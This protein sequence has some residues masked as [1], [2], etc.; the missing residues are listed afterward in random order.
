M[1]SRFTTVPFTTAILAA[2]L[3]LPASAQQPAD[4]LSGTPA[5]TFRLDDIVVT[6]A[7]LPLRLADAPGAITVITGEQL[8]AS[9]V[10]YVADALRTVPG[11]AVVQSSG[12]GALTSVFIRGG[13]SDYV[14]VL[15]DG[16]QVNDP[17]GAFDWAHLRADDIERIEVLRGPASVLYGSDAVSGVV[18]IF[19]R[20][21]G[22]PRVEASAVSGMGDKRGDGAEGTYRT[23]AVDASISGTAAA[24]SGSG[25]RLNYGVSGAHHRSNGLH[26][27]NSDYD[28]TTLS[29]RLQLI[30]PAFDAAFTAR[31]TNHTYHYPT[32][33]SGEIVDTNQFATGDGLSFGVDGGYRI[34]ER[35]ELRVLATSHR[36]DTRTDDPAE[37][38]TEDVYWSTGEQARHKLDARINARLLPG[39]ILTGG[40]EREWQSSRTAYE[41]VS[42]WGV[43]SDET[44]ETRRNTGW[45]AQLHAT[46]LTGVAA[47]VGGRID[48]NAAFGTFRTGRAALSWSPVAA[49]RLH[50]AWGT[51]FKEPTFFE[52]FAT[53]FTR[54]NPELEPEQARSI[55]AGIEQSL[56]GGAVTLGATWFDQRFR[57]LIQYT[58]STP[59]PE[60]PN[61]YNIG[62]ARSRGVE[63]SA[64]A[65]LGRLSSTAHYTHTATR[66]IDA[67]FGEDAAFQQG[68]R[69]LRRPRHVAAL[70]ASYRATRSVRA[71]LDVRHT[72]A[73]DDLDFTDPDNWSGLRVLMPSFTT[74]DAGAELGV[75]R[76]GAGTLDITLR[77]RNLLD[78]RYQEIYNFPAAGRVLQLGFRATG[79]L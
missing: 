41:S 20:A 32:S 60:A 28:N 68:E 8:R 27:F 47:T 39:T 7:R 37:P 63:L 48:E 51:A 4:S 15:V 54:G 64:H 42:A 62:A 75:L 29:A 38:G 31:G 79:G 26:A 70:A 17:G 52:T 78:A 35:L 6:A 49:T 71:L 55:E 74:V 10:R 56:A 1:Q 59:T 45:Y 14:Q 72:G 40:V 67:G 69:L 12:P 5:D 61:Y 77:V 65:S 2:V 44:A 33:G 16:I 43:F 73:R 19:T 22:A 11:A 36:N 24:P 21:G 13:E 25:S 3:A 18:Q 50:A 53:G 66:V 57:N 9:G 30:A 46:P 76:R 58:V 23:N 34:T